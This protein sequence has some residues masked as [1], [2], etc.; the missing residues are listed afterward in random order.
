[1]N[2]TVK[3]EDIETFEK[4]VSEW[5]RS[6]AVSLRKISAQIGMPQSSWNRV[7]ARLEQKYGSLINR[8]ESPVRLTRAGGELYRRIKNLSKPLGDRTVRIAFP[9]LV[10]YSDGVA[11]AIAKFVG[12]DEVKVKDEGWNQAE[13]KNVTIVEPVFN[14][15]YELDVLIS[16][17]MRGKVDFAL[18]WD[19]E[20]R[21]EQI[22]KAPVSVADPAKFDVVVVSNK[23]E[24][25][26]RVGPK[27]ESLKHL[28]NFT[29]ASLPFDAQV[30]RESIPR[31]IMNSVTKTVGSYSEALGL[32]KL[33]AADFC[34]VPAFYDQLSRDEQLGSLYYSQPIGTVNLRILSRDAISGGS[35]AQRFAEFLKNEFSEAQVSDQQFENNRMPADVAFF[36]SLA[37]DIYIAADEVNNHPM[38]WCTGRLELKSE[39]E[40]GDSFVGEI[41]NQF[42]DKFEVTAKR[43]DTMFVVHANGVGDHKQSCS[44]FVSVFSWTSVEDGVICGSWSGLDSR[45]RPGVF[46]TIFSKELLSPSD[47]G[48]FIRRSGLRS[49]LSV[50]RFAWQGKEL[51]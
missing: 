44:E 19:V 6:G 26:S 2:E 45:D 7:L 46:G 50:P 18:L 42:Q 5:N 3:L 32:V 17:L 47:V 31:D 36:E 39:G 34:V 37:Y 51:G 48:Y 1:M 43:S 11:T 9:R 29:W 40:N 28:Q 41:V 27:R 12:S 38:R 49:Y 22:R 21:R 14:Q 33:R 24:V 30:C 4:F 15:R 13:D 10:Q 25:I 23:A 35:H 8:K 20:Q 16:D